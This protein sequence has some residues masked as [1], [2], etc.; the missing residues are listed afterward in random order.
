[1]LIVLTI[2]AFICLLAAI[3]FVFRFRSNRKFTINTLIVAVGFIVV[4]TPAAVVHFMSTRGIAETA[5]KPLREVI[6]K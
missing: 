5:A 1:M 2:S 4:W 6:I 3:R